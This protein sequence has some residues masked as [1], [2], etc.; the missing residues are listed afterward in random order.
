MVKANKPVRGERILHSKYRLAHMSQAPLR[1]HRLTNGLLIAIFIIALA[2]RPNQFY[3]PKSCRANFRNARKLDR[4]ANCVSK[5]RKMHRSR[6]ENSAEECVGCQLLRA[7]SWSECQVK[8][9]L[10]TH[11]YWLNL[12]LFWFAL[13][14]IERI[15]SIFFTFLYFNINYILVVLLI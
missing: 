13:H 12:I 15:F 1:A 5:S 2:F 10:V 8:V 3:T 4:S 9:Y 11:I 7:S 6:A 14:L